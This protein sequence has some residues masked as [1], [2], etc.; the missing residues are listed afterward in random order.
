MPQVAY[1]KSPEQLAAASKAGNASRPREFSSAS[2]LILF[3]Y[4]LGYNNVSFMG[5]FW[6]MYGTFFR[7][8]ITRFQ[9]HDV[10]EVVWDALIIIQSSAFIEIINSAFGFVRAP[11]MT[12]AMQVASRLFLV[13]GVNYIFPEVQSHWAF[14]TMMIAWSVTECIRYSY[15]TLNLIGQVPKFLTWARYN[16]F[17]VLY[18]LGVGSE[19]MMVYQALPYAYEWNPYYY[20]FMIVVALVYLPGFPVLF[21]HMLAQRKKYLKGTYMVAEKKQHKD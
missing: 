7:I 17:L 19:L 12:T 6:V 21:M 3:F 13:W 11:V 14:S 8:A 5:W 16:F 10:H 18:P 4:L 20:Y 2:Q 9:F 15:Y 1:T